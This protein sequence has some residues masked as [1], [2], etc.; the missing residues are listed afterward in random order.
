VRRLPAAALA[1]LAF[2][3]RAD[4]DRP[5]PFHTPKSL[6]ARLDEIHAAHPKTTRLVTIATTKRGDVKSLE[7]DLD[8]KFDK[9]SPVLLLQGGVHGG[10]WISTETVLR[11][12]EV[13]V[14]PAQAGFDGVVYRFIP[15]VNME[16]FAIGGRN[17]VDD[18]G[19]VYDPNREFPVPGGPDKMSRPLIQSLRDY[20]SRGKVVAV[21]DYHSAAEC[22]LWPW[23]YTGKSAPADIESLADVS[24][25]MARS[26]GYCWGQVAHVIRYKHQGTAADWYQH[27][28]GAPTILMELAGVDDPGSQTTD[29]ILIDQERP[30]RIFLAWMEDRGLKRRS[31]APQ[32]GGGAP[33]CKATTI[34]IGAGELG[35]RASGAACDGKRHGRWTFEYATGEKM[36]EGDYERGL[37]Q[38]PWRTFHRDGSKQDVGQYADG[39]PDGT[40][41]RFAPNGQKIEERSFSKGRRDGMISRWTVDG[42]LWQVRWCSK[43]TCSTRCKATKKQFC[44]I[45]AD[46]TVQ[47][48]P[49]AKGTKPTKP[50]KPKSKPGAKP[51]TP[52]PAR[53]RRAG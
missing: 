1:V 2:A 3:G 33:T 51:T 37:E 20:V 45:L 17:A 13:V 8:G 31:A 14:D 47:L 38:G 11:L 34:T 21:L 18:A 35:Y 4:A 22:L 26:V 5:D 39:K 19:V 42:N 41:T 30:F 23:A 50:A 15:A 46:G 7:V 53:S 27:A 12:A 10:E 44:E 36:R 29:Q 43:G 52:T 16:G 25:S 28:L 48:V 9:K 49:P 32:F 40:W 6:N 24:E